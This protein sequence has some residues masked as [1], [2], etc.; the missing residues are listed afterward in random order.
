MDK[1]KSKIIVKDGHLW[2]DG[3]KLKLEFGDAEQIE[4]I[5]KANKR[6]E[7]FI[8][9]EIEPNCSYEIKG[10]AGFFC[11]CGK[12][13]SVENIEADYEGDTSCFEG[14]VKF[15]NA[16]NNK[17]QLVIHREYSTRGTRRVCISEK[18]GVKLFRN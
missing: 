6:L 5:K 13:L 10:T 4:A 17:Y 11:M 1:E 18:L 16:C 15:C 14:Q 2:R 8:N 12:L 7:Q 3:V 9:G